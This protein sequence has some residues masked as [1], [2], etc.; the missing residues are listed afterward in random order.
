M[1]KGPTELSTINS[2]VVWVLPILQ[3]AASDRPVNI[4]TTCSS[5]SK[6]TE[7]LLQ[8]ETRTPKKV[9]MYD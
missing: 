3:T 5:L 9:R 7:L 2:N 6:E 8:K 1:D 4:A